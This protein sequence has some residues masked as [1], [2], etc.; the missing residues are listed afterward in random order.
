MYGTSRVMTSLHGGTVIMSLRI[1]IYIYEDG[2]S[3]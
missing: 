3:G 1:A 2:N